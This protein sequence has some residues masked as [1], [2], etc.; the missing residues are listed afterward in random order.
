MV[1]KASINGPNRRHNRVGDRTVASTILE[2]TANEKRTLVEKSSSSFRVRALERFLNVNSGGEKNSS[3]AFG[4]ACL[5]TTAGTNGIGQALMDK[6]F[7]MSECVCS[8]FDRIMMY[9]LFAMCCFINGTR[10]SLI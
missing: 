8:I 7:E 3:H 4:D 6:H 9:I 10:I 2:K 5:F 1:L